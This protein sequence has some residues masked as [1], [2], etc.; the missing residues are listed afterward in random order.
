MSSVTVL[1]GPERRHRWSASGRCVVEDARPLTDH[2]ALINYLQ[3]AAIRMK[4]RPRKRA[5]FFGA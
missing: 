5:A 2:Q 1:S 4:L 3:Q